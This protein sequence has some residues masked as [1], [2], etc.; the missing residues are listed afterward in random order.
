[1]FTLDNNDFFIMNCLNIDNPGCSPEGTSLLWITQLFNGSAWA[2]VTPENYKATKNRLA[3]KLISRYEEATGIKRTDSIEEIAIA[4]P[5]TFARYLNTPEGAIY[6]Y[7]TAGWDAMLP[8]IMTTRD[9]QWIR[10]LQ[11]CGGHGNRTLGY[12]ST[13]VN[14]YQTGQMVA[15]GILAAQA[16]KEAK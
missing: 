12:S 3:S 8:R 1:M 11:F 6:A 4:T 16:A 7:H 10:G 13:Y 2:E 9:E 5:A 15:Q 14:G